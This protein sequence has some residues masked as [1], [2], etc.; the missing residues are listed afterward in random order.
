VV[1]K[2]ATDFL[3][4][5]FVCQFLYP[6]TLLNL[7]IHFNSFYGVF[8][9]FCMFYHVI[10]KYI[11]LVISNLDDFSFSCLIALA[12]SSRTMLNRSGEGGHPY[13]VSDLIGKVFSFS[14]LIMI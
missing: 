2:N 5:I 1:N 12:G 7:L 13:L 4:L 9:V 14:P 6:A 3:K 11:I 10:C 8:R